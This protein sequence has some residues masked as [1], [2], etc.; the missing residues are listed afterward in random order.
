MVVTDRQTDKQTDRP[1]YM[2]NN[3]V[4]LM[5]HIAMRRKVFFAAY[6]LSRTGVRQVVFWTHRAYFP[7]GV[8]TA[9]EQTEHQPS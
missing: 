5:L 2:Y 6:E 7:M 8:F 4:H 1:R 9:Q 3:R